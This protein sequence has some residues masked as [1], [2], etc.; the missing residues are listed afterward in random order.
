MAICRANTEGVINS[1]Q[2]HELVHRMDLVVPW[3]IAAW[4]K[5]KKRL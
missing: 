4:R 3:W 5:F 1:H 2:L